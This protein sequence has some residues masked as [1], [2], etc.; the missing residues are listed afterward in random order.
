MTVPEEVAGL[1][2]YARESLRLAFTREFSR[3][4]AKHSVRAVVYVA[5]AIGANAAA[6]A[7]GHWAIPEVPWLLALGAMGVLVALPEPMLGMCLCMLGMAVYWG[8]HPYTRPVVVAEFSVVFAAAWAV[9]E[10][11][12]ARGLRH[13]AGE[14]ERARKVPAAG[15]S[16]QR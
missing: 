5:V 14:L 8:L 1:V 4:E 11:H 12:M 13:M 2:A 10:W 9:V 6:A 16:L 7:V 3:L 15:D